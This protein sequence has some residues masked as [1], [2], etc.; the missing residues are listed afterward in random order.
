MTAISQ[1]AVIHG[2]KGGTAPDP[3]VWDQGSRAKQR[4]V[5]IGMN[6]DLATLPGSPGFFCG[7]WVQVDG[8]GIT[9]ADVAVWP[10]SAV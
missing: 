5:E 9:G 10:C 6:V 1:V 3:F 7:P 4:K 2:G 8:G